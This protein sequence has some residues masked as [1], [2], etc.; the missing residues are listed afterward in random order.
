MRALSKAS[1]KITVETL[2]TTVDD[3]GGLSES[4]TSATS[5]WA[6]RENIKGKSGVEGE[7]EFNE[8]DAKFTIR[9]SSTTA[10]YSPAQ[11][12]VTQGGTTFDIVAIVDEPGDR[13]EVR[14]LY[15]KTLV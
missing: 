3:L 14:H 5:I 13:P 6:Q 9:H 7:R 11:Q 10:G 12:R 4:W 15:C 8:A 2:S 1:R